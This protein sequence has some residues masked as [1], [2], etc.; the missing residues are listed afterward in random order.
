MNKNLALESALSHF[1]QDSGELLIGGRSIS[2]IAKEYGTPLYIYNRDIIHWRHDTMR[3]FIPGDVQLF[4]AV[5]ANPHSGIIRLMGDLYD[6]FDI[7]SIGEMKKLIGEGVSP[8]VMSFAGPGKRIEELEFAL[9][10][11][12]GSI[13]IESEQ[14]LDH[15]RTLCKGMKISANIMIRVN[16]MFEL[17]QSGMGMGG[18]RQFGIDSDRVPE[19]LESIRNDKYIDFQGLHIFSGSQN[20]NADSLVEHFDKIIGYALDLGSAMN[21]PMKVINIGG[22]LGIPYFS[23]EKDLEITTV[24]EGL[25]SVMKKL[26]SK[27]KDTQIRMELGRYIVG[28]CGIYLCRVLYRKIS[29][30]KVF[31][32]VD[33]G[34]H[35]HLA[36]SG[37]LGQSLVRRP[38]PLVTANKIDKPIER[39][40]VVGPLCTPLDTFGTVDLQYADE[41]DLIAVMNSGAYGL[42]ASPNGF[43]SRNQAKEIIN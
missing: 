3:K 23:H 42:T 37:N 11:K 26:H 36:A 41:D 31:L 38:M 34:M 5:K 7:S 43:L 10:H 21:I 22:G 4:Y 16:P 25:A 30:G 18:P 24:G 13:S 14:E 2:A 29:Q 33:G 20:L 6:G 19:V 17:T 35:H 39:V 8:T 28:E 1:Y 32:I 40:T 27:L 9:S 12:I 15:I